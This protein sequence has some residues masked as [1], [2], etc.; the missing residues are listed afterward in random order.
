MRPRTFTVSLVAAAA[1]MLPLAGVAIAQP[2]DRDCADFSSQEEA[3]AALLPG[4]PE[5]LD[6]N[7]NGQAC[8]NYDYGSATPAETTD[9]VDEQPEET[10]APTTAPVEAD[11]SQ[12]AVVPRGGVDTGDGT[13]GSEPAPF[14][15]GGVLVVGA[16][17]AAARRRAHTAR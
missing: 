17:A 11:D 1:V 12:V 16:V 14:L 13:S 6:A 10:A 15:I 7:G 2:G 5:R 9:P 8:E 3:Q 4:D